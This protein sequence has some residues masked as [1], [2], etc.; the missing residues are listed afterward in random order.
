MDDYYENRS[1]ITMLAKYNGYYR[2]YLAIQLQVRGKGCNFGD[3]PSIVI[4][5]L[6]HSMQVWYDY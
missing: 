5:T 4:L 3:F 2:F 1:K 6:N